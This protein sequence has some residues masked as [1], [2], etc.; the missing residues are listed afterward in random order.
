MMLTEH[1]ASMTINDFIDSGATSGF[2]HAVLLRFNRPGVLTGTGNATITK[3]TTSTASWRIDYT[4]STSTTLSREGS[5][6]LAQDGAI[7]SN[8]IS[9]SRTYTGFG[10]ANG[11]WIIWMETDAS[12]QQVFRMDILIRK[13]KGLSEASL[14]GRFNLLGFYQES[15]TENVD[16]LFGR[17]AFDGNGEYSDYTTRNSFGNASSTGNQSYPY[18]VAPDGRITFVGGSNPIGF[19]TRNT[20]RRWFIF[21]DLNPTGTLGFFIALKR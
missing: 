1:G 9:A 18:T 4:L 21:P 15:A 5:L 17:I 13:G 7:S 14:N 6:M 3:N 10:E 20:S 16:S 11:D 19:V 8:D 12:S 2:Y